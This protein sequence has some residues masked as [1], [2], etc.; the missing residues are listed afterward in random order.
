M[1]DLGQPCS[2]TYVALVVIGLWND[3]IMVQLLWSNPA[4][5]DVH[6]VGTCHATLCYDVVDDMEPD[7][8][9]TL[10]V[11]IKIMPL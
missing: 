4:V 7:N 2:V 11:A 6:V 1:Q 3:G 10:V 8:A 5:E 9:T